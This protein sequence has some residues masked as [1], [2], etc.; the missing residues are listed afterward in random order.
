MQE[1]K[2]IYPSSL[3]KYLSIIAAMAVLLS[4]L[5]NFVFSAVRTEVDLLKMYWWQELL[6]V[7]VGTIFAYIV[8]WV[9][10]YL[11]SGLYNFLSSKTRGIVVEMRDVSLESLQTKKVEEN[12]KEDE[13]RFVV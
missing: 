7:L 3:A 12:K 1:I 5:L 2:K 4:G 10:G 11:F 9:I 13:E 6:N 8:F